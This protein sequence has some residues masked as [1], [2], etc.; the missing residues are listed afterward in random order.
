MGHSTLPPGAIPSAVEGTWASRGLTIEERNCMRALEC[1]TRQEDW[2]DQDWSL[3]VPDCVERLCFDMPIGSAIDDILVALSRMAEEKKALGHYPLFDAELCV[4]VADR[5]LPGTIDEA[6]RDF[7]GRHRSRSWKDWDVAKIRVDDEFTPY[8]I[9]WGEHVF[10]DPM[11]HSL[12]PLYTKSLA[13]GQVDFDRPWDSIGK[14]KLNSMLDQR[15]PCEVR[16]LDGHARVTSYVNGLHPFEGDMHDTFET[17]LNAALPLWERCIDSTSFNKRVLRLDKDDEDKFIYEPAYPPPGIELGTERLQRWETNLRGPDSQLQVIIQAETFD[18]TDGLGPAASPKTDSRGPWRPAGLPHE[19]VCAVAIYCFDTDS[20]EEVSLQLRHPLDQDYLDS[21][22]ETYGRDAPHVKRLCTTLN[23]NLQS[24]YNPLQDESFADDY[25]GTTDASLIGTVTLCQGRMVVFPACLFYRLHVGFSARCS[26]LTMFLVDPSRPIWSSASVPPQ[27]MQWL[28][29]PIRE[30]P[31]FARLPEEVWLLIRQHL[32]SAWD[33]VD[34]DQARR[35]RNR[36]KNNY[37]RLSD[38]MV[39]DCEQVSWELS[40]G[41]TEIGVHR[42]LM[43][44][45]YSDSTSFLAKG[46]ISMAKKQ[47]LTDPMP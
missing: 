11:M 33:E 30:L 23:N 12:N 17:I 29:P 47:C 32:H 45:F 37:D 20:Y 27:S 26:L 21:I 38:A 28:L 4:L 3:E 22:P 40:S 35:D 43:D 10:L 5:P 1:I 6:L 19:H 42:K 36:M 46:M 13:S 8:E 39:R 7:A 14:G 25:E 34:R 24:K 15:L 41:L 44:G 16:I 9:W 2:D 31:W 18:S